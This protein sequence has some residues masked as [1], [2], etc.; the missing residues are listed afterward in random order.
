MVLLAWLLVSSWRPPSPALQDTLQAARTVGSQA[1]AA[2][3][4]CAVTCEPFHKHQC[5]LCKHMLTAPGQVLHLLLQ[6]VERPSQYGLHAVATNSGC[7]SAP[8]FQD[9]QFLELIR[10]V[11]MAVYPADARTPP[12]LTSCGVDVCCFSRKEHR[13]HPQARRGRRGRDTGSESEHVKPKGV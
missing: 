7:G 9:L 11:V 5:L 1:L 6:R 12:Q 4:Q 10:I 3:A 8:E 13:L 2:E